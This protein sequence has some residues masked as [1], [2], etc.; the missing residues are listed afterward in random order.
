MNKMRAALDNYIGE[1]KLSGEL[2]YFVDQPQDDLG[3]NRGVRH[4]V[5]FRVRGRPVYS[6]H[7]FTYW[8]D[9]DNKVT[10]R[11]GDEIFE[12]QDYSSLEK[13]LLEI[14]KNPTVQKSISQ[15]E[16]FANAGN[17]EGV[18]RTI[19]EN[20]LAAGDF[21]IEIPDDEFQKIEDA[22]GMDDNSV[23]VLMVM[24]SRLRRLAS[25]F[26]PIAKPNYYKCLDVQGYVMDII[27][28]RQCEDKIEIHIKNVR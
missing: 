28:I 13:K 7:L 19:D 4:N 3:E 1:R 26:V 9:L 6:A 16:E 22:F 20:T 21:M 10:I 23:V 11:W 24:E 15:L 18:V 2:V 12:F 27:E 17:K 8:I 14:L 25:R 5:E